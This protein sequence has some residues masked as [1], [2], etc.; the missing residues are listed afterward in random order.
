M[1]SILLDYYFLHLVSLLA[2]RIWDEGDADANLDRLNGLLE[3]L[4]GPDGSGQR[5]VD[6]AETLILIATSHF[7]IVERGYAMLLDRV[8]LLNTAHRERIAQAH[9]VSMGSHLRF[10]FEATY[11][12][13]TVVM[14]DD[15]VADYPWLCFALLTVM[16]E[17]ARL[18]A[19]GASDED[20]APSIEAIL[21]G[22]SADARAFIGQPPSSLSGSEADRGAFRELFLQHRE[23]LV[24]RFQPLQAAGGRLPT[25]RSPS[26]STSRTTSSR[27]RSSTRCCAAARGR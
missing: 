5:F 22:L 11:G 24:E 18:D 20:K 26:S 8:R 27:A 14:R 9:A 23:A 12:R 10:G 6:D 25:R 17:F 19:A 3:Q 13:D 16:Q 15:N 1:L 4:Q 21:N 7:E 2:L